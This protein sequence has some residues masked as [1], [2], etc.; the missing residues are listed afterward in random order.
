[1]KMYVYNTEILSDDNS[2][3]GNMIV[4]A[5]NEKEAREKILGHWLAYDM[6]GN[7]YKFREDDFYLGEIDVIKRYNHPFEETETWNDIILPYRQLLKDL[8]ADP[9]VYDFDEVIYLEHIS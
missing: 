1:M 2:Y 6:R 3:S 8:D 7:Y 4:V 5:N 9:V